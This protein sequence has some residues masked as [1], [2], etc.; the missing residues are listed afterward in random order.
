MLILRFMIDMSFR[1]IN[2]AYKQF[3]RRE[4]AQRLQYD[5]IESFWMIQNVYMNNF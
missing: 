1:P 4:I 5:E 2:L 3:E